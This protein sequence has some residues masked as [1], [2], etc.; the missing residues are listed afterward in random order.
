MTFAVIVGLGIG[1]IAGH[2]IATARFQSSRAELSLARRESEAYARALAAL[3]Y[4]G[5]DTR[6]SIPGRAWVAAST[7]AYVLKLHFTDDDALVEVEPAGCD[8]PWAVCLDDTGAG[9]GD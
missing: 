2:A 5:Q 8:G 9:R 1:V 7:S 3:T 6:M 4:L